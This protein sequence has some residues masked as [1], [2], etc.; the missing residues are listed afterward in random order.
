M[1]KLPVYLILFL[2]LSM[3]LLNTS[4][5]STSVSNS[6]SSNGQDNSLEEEEP[7]MSEVSPS[8]LEGKWKLTEFIINDENI[9]IVEDTAPN[10]I[11]ITFGKPDRKDFPISGFFGVNKFFDGITKIHGF[12]FEIEGLATTL[13]A[14][15]EG[16]MIFEEEFKKCLLN[17]DSIYFGKKSTLVISSSTLNSKLFFKKIK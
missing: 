11:G 15:P 2:S 1:K 8:R 3:L 4:C 12:D 5:V 17:S 13:R 6:D 10:I 16:H 7:A 9:E 14:G